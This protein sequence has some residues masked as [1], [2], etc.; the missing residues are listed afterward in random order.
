MSA[1]ESSVTNTSVI[2]PSSDIAD[3]FPFQQ[4]EKKWQCKWEEERTFKTLLEGKGDKFY[5]LEMFPYPSGKLHMGHLR[6]YAIGDVMARFYSM[7]GMRVLHPMGFDAFGLPAENAA[8]K[9]KIHPAEWTYNNIHEMRQ[10][11]KALGLSYDWDREFATCDEEYYK[12]GQWIFLKFWEHGLVYRKEGLL[13]W[14][15]TCQTVLANEQ[16]VNGLCWRCDAVVT[17][18][19]MPQWYIKI[20]AYAE[21][22]LNDLELLNEWPQKVVTMQRN[23]IGR[24]EGAEIFFR[25]ADGPS[26]GT[27]I[28]V[29]TTRPDTIF[30]ATY[31]VLAPEHPLVE[32]LISGTKEEKSCRQF[33][34]KVSRMDKVS[35][36]DEATVK[37]GVFTGR[38]AVNPVNGEKIPIWIANYV[39]VEYGTGAIMAVPTH[40]Q[41]DFEF[42]Q[43]YQLPMRLVIKPESAEFDTAE[44]M[45]EAWTGAGLMV[46]SGQFNGMPNED[47]KKAIISWMEEKE[48][49][50]GTINYRLRDWG[51]SRQRY[52]GMPIPLIHCEKCG[53]VPVD[54]NDLPVNLPIDIELT[55]EGSLLAR[56][57]GFVHTSCPKCGGSAQRETDTVDTFFDSSWYFLRYTDAN[58]TEKP[59]DPNTANHWM[60]VDLYIGGVEHAVLHLLYSRFFTKALKDIGMLNVDEP[61]TKLVTQGMVTKDGA[62]MSKSKG[63]VVDPGEILEKYGA[64]A[65]RIFIL[66]TSPPD[67]DLEWSDE[68]VIGSARFVDRVYRLI[69]R[70][71]HVL[72]EEVV[73]IEEN[74]SSAAIDLRRLCHNAIQAVTTDIGERMNLNTAIAKIMELVNEMYRLTSDGDINAADFPIFREAAETL[75]LLL[76]P[77]APHLC[78]ELWES[79]GKQEFVQKQPWPSYNP[80]F[81]KVETMNII[82]QVNGK[83]RGKV[84]V[85]ANADEDTIWE[86]ANQNPQITR[87]FEGKEIRK[88]I[89]ILGKLMN[90]V[91]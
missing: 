73:E 2:S 47:G 84:E 16:V 11:Q 87:W 53:I 5:C 70:Y 79:I 37:E 22:L 20:T 1:S 35:R 29:F 31:M 48:I 41:R 74:P 68:G 13:N 64:D 77:F 40:D 23:W 50:K 59:F 65:A 17:Q 36:T 57:Q 69:M 44:E 24:S 61:F 54:E 51:I 62:K 80:E 88:K 28:P 63:N 55:G 10:Q 27:E 15:P 82:I 26:E 83:V 72:R 81:L 66:F 78:E 45:D 71:A 30:G 85:P 43:K 91:V 52:W 67:R 86:A 49:G 4:V 39:L 7:Q 25:V 46:N 8:I 12:W 89:Y 3:H 76:N 9:N 34:G 32:I 75:I 18:K 60:P 6:N 21:Q 33:M 19:Y 38:Y 90:V 42:A 14:C 56:H 58:N